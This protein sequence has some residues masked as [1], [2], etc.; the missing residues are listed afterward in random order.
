MSADGD[1]IQGGETAYYRA[2]IQQYDKAAQRWIR[3]S[4][5]IVKRYTDER[6]DGQTNQKRYNILW[7]NI[8]TLKPAIYAQT[9]KP[10][11]QRR[12]LDKDPVGRRAS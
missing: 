3:R 7:S 10:E 12:F 9:P 11:V 1:P 2:L 4:K 5:K 6:E 8:E